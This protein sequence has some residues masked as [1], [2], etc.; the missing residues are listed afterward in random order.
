MFEYFRNKRIER[1]RKMEYKKALAEDLIEVLEY[2]NDLVIFHENNGKEYKE[3]SV[4]GARTDVYKTPIVV[5]SH[6][7][8]CPCKNITA[9][10]NT[11]KSERINI[12]LELRRD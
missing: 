2:V 11:A 8:N 12:I 9:L 4:C 7:D 3:C 5:M 10:L 1:I 6:K